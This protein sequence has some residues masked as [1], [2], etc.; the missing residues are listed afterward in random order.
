LAAEAKKRNGRVVILSSPNGSIEPIAFGPF[1]ALCDDVITEEW[2]YCVRFEL[3]CDVCEPQGAMYANDRNR[4]G[5]GRRQTAGFI[6]HSGGGLATSRT[7][8]DTMKKHF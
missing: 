7:I 4:D 8:Y 2:L 5:S 1:D 3:R 6:N